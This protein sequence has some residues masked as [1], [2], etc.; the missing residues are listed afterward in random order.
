MKTFHLEIL[1]PD[2]EF[3][4]GEAVSL[5]MPIHDGMMGIMANHT[6]LSASISDGEVSFT[7]ADGEVVRCAV[8]RGMVDVTDN[9]VQLLC[10]SALAP[11]EIDE[12]AERIA[13]EE[14]MS[15]LKKKQSKQDFAIWQMTFRTAMNNLRVK[16]K[17]A[18]INL[19]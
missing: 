5:V 8:M 7:K 4:S 10:E 3:Y 14:A 15:E 19:K 2:R 16:N 9:R 17:S 13:L 12:A 11:D 1:S 18:D 6:P